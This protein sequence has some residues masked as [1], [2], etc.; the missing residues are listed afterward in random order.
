MHFLATTT[1]LSAL[2]SAV[3][4]TP[5][6]A[7]YHRRRQA[8]TGST[9]SGP[10]AL[11]IVSSGTFNGSFLTFAGPNSYIIPDSEPDYSFSF[12]LTGTY[13][14]NLGALLYKPLLQLFLIPNASEVNT[15][16]AAVYGQPSAARLSNIPI[17]LSPES[18]PGVEN[19]TPIE[20]FQ[21]SNDDLLISIADSDGFYLCPYNVTDTQ[22]GTRLEWNND[23]SSAKEDDCNPIYMQVNY[24]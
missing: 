5:F 8:T 14:A 6:S 12:N 21:V 16:Y 24:L 4:A 2:V 13:G 19:G 18:T 23:A 1:L 22:T 11:Q 15:T 20:V 7:S 10:L 9:L 3:I 17:I